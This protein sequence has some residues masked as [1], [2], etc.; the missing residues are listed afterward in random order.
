MILVNR[1]NKDATLVRRLKLR[2]G[3][4]EN[5]YFLTPSDNMLPAE[6]FN[7]KPSYTAVFILTE[8]L[9]VEPVPNFTQ[10]LKSGSDDCLI[11]TLTEQLGFN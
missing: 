4:A 8:P 7:I 5:Q 6:D 10:F 11:H 9:H 1:V 2:R 3:D